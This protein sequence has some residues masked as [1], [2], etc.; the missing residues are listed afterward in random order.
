[1]FLRTDQAGPARLAV[2]DRYDGSSPA[3]YDELNLAGH[4][5]DDPARVQ[6]N[7]ARVA[8]WFGLPLDRLLFMD[9]V[10][11][12]HVAVVDGPAEPGAPPPRADALVTR[13]ADLALV[14]VVA[15]CAPVLL[16]SAAGG[17]VAVAHAGRRGM[18]G[19][20]VT[21]TL[22]A[23]Q[24]L[25]GDP[26]TTTA[27]VGPAICGQCYEVPASMQDEVAAMVPAARSTTRAGMPALDVRAGIAAQLRAAGVATV[28]VDP[29]CTAE[30]EM[31]Y[32]HRR[33]GVTGRFAGIA[34][35]SDRPPGA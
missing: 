15:D 2:T 3:P 32:S 35:R 6:S 23:M 25:G 20:V 24:D 34:V 7:R 33:N 1:M 9:Q 17:V 13:A 10:H 14:V 27:L 30:T 8:R 19:G 5:G 12:S 4:V 22:T 11:G 29:T 21:A 28:D 16:S 31:L 18:A 26:A